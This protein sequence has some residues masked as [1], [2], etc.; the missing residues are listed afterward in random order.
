MES[1]CA[2]NNTHRH[3]EI[4]SKILC[5]IRTALFH[6]FT[7]RFTT[8]Q[9]EYLRGR[10]II[11]FRRLIQ[12]LNGRR[13]SETLLLDTSEHAM[14]E[15]CTKR[16]IESIL[17]INIKSFERTHSLPSSGLLVFP[18]SGLM[19]GCPVLTLIIRCHLRISYINVNKKGQEKKREIRNLSATRTKWKCK[20]VRR[21]FLQYTTNRVWM[22]GHI[23]YLTVPVH[24][25]ILTGS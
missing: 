18:V 15:T 25:L 2:V 9:K 3:G 14:I 22:R 24:Y 6:W 4:Q 7:T 16:F 19:K 1:S 10:R 21:Y 13:L 11:V 12:Y 8:I 17:Y 5:K 20:K 23:W